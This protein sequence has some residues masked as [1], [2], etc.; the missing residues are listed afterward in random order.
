MKEPF[1]KTEKPI[2]KNTFGGLIYL[3]DF[4]SEYR[5]KK[6]AR[7]SIIASRIAQDKRFDAQCQRNIEAR[8]RKQIMQSGE[9]HGRRPKNGGA[10][11]G[12]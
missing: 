12:A 9:S 6:N 8:T 4:D 5:S 11:F 7:G 10:Q 1:H 3:S 2:Q